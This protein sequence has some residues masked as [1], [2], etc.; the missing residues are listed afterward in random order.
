MG[1][2]FGTVVSSFIN[3]V[4]MLVVSPIM[5]GVNLGHV[6]YMLLGQRNTKQIASK[7]SLKCHITREKVE[8]ELTFKAGQRTCSRRP[9]ALT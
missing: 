5:G 6:K 4:F 9:I 1:G 2:T 3:D 7:L 8:A